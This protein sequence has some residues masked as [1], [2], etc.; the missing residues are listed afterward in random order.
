MGIYNQTAYTVVAETNFMNS[1]T[2][3][4]EKIAKP[5]LARRLFVV[6]S[7]QHY[8]RNLHNAGFRTFDSVIDESYDEE[9]DITKRYQM[10]YEQMQYLMQEPQNKIFEEIKNITEYNYHHLLE[11]QW[12]S[13]YFRVLKSLLLDHTRQN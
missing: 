10:I 11:T 12:M 1:Y 3:F 6:F 7:G 2:F 4:T 9:P 13:E 8:L 5:M